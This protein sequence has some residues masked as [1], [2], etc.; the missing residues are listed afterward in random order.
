MEDPVSTSL[1][2]LKQC[3]LVIEPSQQITAPSFCFNRNNPSP[4]FTVQN[5]E[6]YGQDTTMET[7]SEVLEENY[8]TITEENSVFSG[9]NEE[10]IIRDD[11]EDEYERKR[12][13]QKTFS[14][15][16]KTLFKKVSL[17]KILLQLI[18]ISGI[19]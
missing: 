18:I 10:F 2:Y 16:H 3:G 4:D 19:I 9:E 6:E 12:K 1:D 14:K 17:L 7:S 8:E 5:N 13:A 11:E 15:R